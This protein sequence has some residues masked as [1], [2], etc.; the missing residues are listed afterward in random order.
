MS[1]AVVMSPDVGPPG[2]GCSITIWYHCTGDGPSFIVTAMMAD[3]L[4]E[5]LNSARYPCITGPGWRQRRLFIGEYSS[6][7]VVSVL[8]FRFHNKSLKIIDHSRNV[9]GT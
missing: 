5:E 3:N 8:V 1:T 6:R 7:V 9:N 2:L 4:Q